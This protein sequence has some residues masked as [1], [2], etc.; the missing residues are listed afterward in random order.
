MAEC[1][2]NSR[3]RRKR[4]NRVFPVFSNRKS[5]KETNIVTNS[6]ET[7]DIPKAELFIE[8]TV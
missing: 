1:R 3:G 4:N 8:N 6:L 7:R 5:D 2:Q